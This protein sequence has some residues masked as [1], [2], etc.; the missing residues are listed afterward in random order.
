[1]RRAIY[2]ADIK[3]AARIE[4][5]INTKHNVTFEEV[6]EAFLLRGDV[7]A[8]WENHAVHGLRIVALGTTA[9]KRMLIAAFYPID[10]KEGIWALAT[11]RALRT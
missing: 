11:A 9:S 5:K 8:R 4:A 7:D 1:V 6:K 2:I 10:S 3:I